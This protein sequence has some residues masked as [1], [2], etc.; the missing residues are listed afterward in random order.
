M[1]LCSCY[2]IIRCVYTAVPVVNYRYSYI[3]GSHCNFSGIFTDRKIYFAIVLT[4]ALPAKY[5]QLDWFCISMI[6]PKKQW[7]KKDSILKE[8]V[9][10]L[11][12]GSI[13]AT[14][15]RERERERQERESHGS[16][17]FFTRGTFTSL[18]IGFSNFILFSNWRYCHN[19]L[20]WI[21]ENLSIC[22]SISDLGCLIQ[23][24]CA[25]IS[26]WT[27][28]FFAFFMTDKNC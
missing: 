9:L 2:R 17:S 3:C 1:I 19:N 11:F 8:N 6:K 15:E 21:F 14:R 27:L 5:R 26:S 16:G 7:F 20:L 28:I 4:G 22:V 24:V 25:P 12:Y 18:S 23:P 10:L 13:L